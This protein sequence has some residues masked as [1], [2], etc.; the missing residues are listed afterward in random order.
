MDMRSIIF[1]IFILQAAAAFAVPMYRVVDVRDAQTLIIDRNGVAAEVRLAGVLVAP[2][3]Q[4][5][6]VTWLRDTL[7]SHWAMVENGPDGAY[8]YRSPDALYVNG[9]IARRAYANARTP[10]VYLGEADP[11][12]QRAL[13][14]GRSPA[15]VRARA[16]PKPHRV[17]HAPRGAHKIPRL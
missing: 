8:I 2:S 4:P 12:P 3:E 5:L 9:E 15:P 10:M 1:S 13:R 17:R 11:G 6:A 14:T 7:V 16:T